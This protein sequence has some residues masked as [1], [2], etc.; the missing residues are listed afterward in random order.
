MTSR[1]MKR[2]SMSLIIREI[3]IKTTM[4]YHP[5]PVRTAII[6][7]STNNKC[8]RGCGE[9]GTLLNCWW[10]CKWLQPLWKAVWRYLKKLKMDLPFDPVIPLL[11]IHPKE[12]KTLIPKN[13]STSMF[14]AALF[15][16][17]KK[18]KQP[19]CP[20][21]VEWIKQLWDIY[22]MEY[23]SAVKRK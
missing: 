15:T 14:I 5:T 9:R 1:H 21:I 18:W 12:P 22:T 23:Y 8:W 10:E 20:S 19:K 6:N 2:C 7:K 13:I 16:I 4:R 11:G 3:Q 17:T